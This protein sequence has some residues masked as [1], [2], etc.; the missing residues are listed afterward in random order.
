MA[1]KSKAASADS[2]RPAAFKRGAS[3]KPTSV[4]FNF[5]SLSPAAFASE[6]TPWRCPNLSMC[7]PLRTKSRFSPVSGTISAMVPSAT[8]SSQDSAARP[9]LRRRER[10]AWAIL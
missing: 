8:R 4:A 6:T 5:S 9:D 3:P 2:N 7:S 1:S 10:S